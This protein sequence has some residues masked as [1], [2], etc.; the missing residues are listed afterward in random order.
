MRRMGTPALWGSILVL[1]SIALGGAAQRPQTAA[2]NTAGASSGM[3]PPCLVGPVSAACR[4]DWH[5]SGYCDGIGD[6]C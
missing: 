4:G 6:N 2:V 5:A 3:R 1:L